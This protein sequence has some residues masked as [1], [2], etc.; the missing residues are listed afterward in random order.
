MTPAEVR[1]KVREHAETEQLGTGEAFCR[2]APQTRS[3]FKAH[4]SHSKGA[5]KELHVRAS[6]GGPP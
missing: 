6:P 4:E 5:K 1:A 2:R 3:P